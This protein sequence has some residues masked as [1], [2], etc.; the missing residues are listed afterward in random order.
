M[1][2]NSQ[3]WIIQGMMWITFIVSLRRKCIVGGHKAEIAS[4]LF[5]MGSL[6]LVDNNEEQDKEDPNKNYNLVFK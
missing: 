1:S 4:L 5:G 6:S 3:P 2:E